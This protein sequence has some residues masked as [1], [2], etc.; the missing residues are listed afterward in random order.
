MQMKVLEIIASALLLL[1]C[2]PAPEKGGSTI[3]E[4]RDALE[5]QD[6]PVKP[7]NPEEDTYVTE[8]MITAAEA[9]ELMVEKAAAYRN[10]SMLE[11]R[12]NGIYVYSGATFD[13]YVSKPEKLAARIAML[14]FKDVYLS[15]GSS[16]ITNASDALKKFIAACS[17]YGIDVYAIGSAESSQYLANA[18]RVT[19]DVNQILSYNNKVSAGQKF[20]GISADIEPHTVHEKLSATYPY[21]WD[22]SSNYGKGKDNDQLLKLTLERLSTAGTALHQAGLKLGEAIFY[23]YQIYY[24]QGQLE[25]GSTAQFLQSCDYLVTMAYLTSKESIWN[26][27]EPGLKAAGKPNSVSVCVKTR[28]NSDSGSSIQSLGWKN[29]LE[30]AKYVN[31][32]AAAYESYRGFDMFTF[33]GIETMWEWTNDTN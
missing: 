6:T 9:T 32:K 15:P 13:A 23:N 5:N 4:I 22:S 11:G 18:A 30:V 20:A 16:R 24:D 3:D 33:D 17:A 27:S 1:S 31:G 19:Q 12:R 26:K 10:A 29:L 7:D 25:Y 21:T 8:A 28:I 2:S 14:G